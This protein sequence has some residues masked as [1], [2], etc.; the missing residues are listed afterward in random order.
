MSGYVPVECLDKFFMNIRC[1][2]LLTH[3]VNPSHEFAS[4]LLDAFSIKR[5]IV[6][7]LQRVL[8]HNQ[9]FLRQ[10][11]FIVRLRHEQALSVMK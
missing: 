2:F 11:H 9:M 3:R 8:W 6:V 4:S 5:C 7:D 1:V 10:S